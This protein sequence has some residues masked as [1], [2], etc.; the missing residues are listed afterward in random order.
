M[1]KGLP[2]IYQGQELGMANCDFPSIEDIDDVSSRDE[3]RRCLEVG[4]SEEKALEV[5]RHYSRDNGRTPFQWN[6]QRNAGFTTGR[7]WLMVNP[8]YKDINAEAEI[9]HEGSIYEFYK[10][11]I[12]LRTDDRYMDTIL[13]GRTEPV[14]EN[15]KD[16]MAYLRRGEGQDLLVVGNF[17][18]KNAE[19]VMDELKG[20]Q[21]HILLNNGETCVL[22]D[23]K[24]KL[25][26]LQGVVFE[27]K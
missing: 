27:I 23:G 24:I 3:Y 14:L 2:F 7:P 20:K 25:E 19:V 13:Y 22:Q 26:P 6:T 1:Q 5:V 12:A 16:I 11:M 21:G 10:Q 17:R 9:G 18:E 8:Q 15:E 4:Y